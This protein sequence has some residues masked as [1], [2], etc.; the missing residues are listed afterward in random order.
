MESADLILSADQPGKVLFAKTALDGHWRGPAVVVHVLRDAGF[1]VIYLGM[2]T[3]DEIA[4]AAVQEDA[5]LVGLN[6]GGSLA[7]VMRILDE[8]E[9]SAPD[10]GVMLGGTIQPQHRSALAVRGVSTF[11]P[12]SMFSDIVEEARRLVEGRRRTREDVTSA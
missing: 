11:P 8:L 2:A 12:G 4:A 1:E 6:V 9:A 7:V 5:D 3:A 10:V